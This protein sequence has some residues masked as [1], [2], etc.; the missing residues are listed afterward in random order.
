MLDSEFQDV[1]SGMF[2]IKY[3]FRS[4]SL[5][6]LGLMSTATLMMVEALIHLKIAIEY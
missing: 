5:D 2:F 3:G 1:I 4:F 6:E